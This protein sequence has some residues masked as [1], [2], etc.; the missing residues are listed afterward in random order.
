MKIGDT[1]RCIDDRYAFN[2]LRNGELY[3]VEAAYNGTPIVISRGAYHALDRFEKIDKE[4][5]S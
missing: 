2:R 4:D 3:T 1:V 5:K